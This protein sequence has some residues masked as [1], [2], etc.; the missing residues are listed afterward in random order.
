VLFF[1]DSIQAAMSSEPDTIR[2]FAP[3]P[4]DDS[5]NSALL[6]ARRCSAERIVA[7]DTLL[8]SGAPFRPNH[9]VSVVVMPAVDFCDNE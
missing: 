9:P 8:H 3:Q 5:R 7:G 1:F 4:S 2:T 6:T